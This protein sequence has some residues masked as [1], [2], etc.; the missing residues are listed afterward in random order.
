MSLYKSADYAGSA[1]LCN[2]IIASG[3]RKGDIHFLYGLNLMAMDSMQKAIREF[4]VQINSP[5]VTV[6]KQ[7]LPV[8][9]YKALCRLKLGRPD[10]ALLTIMKGYYRE[11]RKR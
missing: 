2:E 5:S 11:F 4:D 1:R 3:T 10:S 9:R 7:H 8:Y 6:K